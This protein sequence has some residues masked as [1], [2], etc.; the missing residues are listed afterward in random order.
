[1][2]ARVSDGGD[3]DV[4]AVCLSTGSSCGAPRAQEEI[5][6]GA[7]ACCDRSTVAAANVSISSVCVCAVVLSV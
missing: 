5:Q 7:R 3:T 1:M 2:R 4:T 6:P